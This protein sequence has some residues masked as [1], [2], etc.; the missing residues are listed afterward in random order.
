SAGDAEIGSQIYYNL[1][2]KINAGSSKLKGFELAYDRP[3]DFMPY[4]F[5]NM[6][7]QLNY[8]YTD[9]SLLQLTRTGYPVGLQDFSENSYN[10]IVYYE[11]DKFSA[12][13]AYNY[14][15]DYYDNLTQANAAQ[16]QKPYA[17]LDGKVTYKIN[18]KWDIS[19]QAQ[20]IT[21]EAKE[22]Y[23]EIEERLTDYTLNDTM[24]RL[25]LQGK[26]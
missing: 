8:T 2:T 19:L 25:T 4:P 16:F 20:N 9:S 12:R 24:I 5:S 18:K 21:N 7:V 3:L 15:D 6:G 17:S 23:Q 22:M 11:D 14:R 1:A 13:L 26:L 10:S